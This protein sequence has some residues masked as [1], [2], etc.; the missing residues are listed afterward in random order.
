[1]AHQLEHGHTS[2]AYLTFQQAKSLGGYVR[3]GER[4]VLLVLYRDV[5]VPTKD[6]HE[7]ENDGRRIFLAKGFTVF[8]LEQTGGLEQFR[9]KLEARSK[10]RFEPLEEC[11]RVVRSTGAVIHENGTHASYTASRD[12][13][14]MPSRSG[15]RTAAGWYGVAYHELVHWSGARHRL[16]RDL[17]GGFG[18]RVYALEEL[19]AE[20][21]AC[22]IAARCGIE[23]VSRSAS[24][25]DSWLEALHG[26][27]RF[28][29]SAGRLATEAAAFIQ[30]ESE[31]DDGRDWFV[32]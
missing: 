15:F 23:H 13:V 30:P 7:G 27:K 20:L 29:F 11:E 12:V 17:S 6:R 18:S 1:M 22:F 19:V 8:N 3:Q 5:L 10:G 16:N 32:S 21:G 4:G 2:S 24:Y 26:D 14:T 25:I 28:I 9:E 31:D